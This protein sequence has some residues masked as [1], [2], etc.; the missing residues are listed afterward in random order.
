MP[1]LA[2]PSDTR[3]GIHRPFDTEVGAKPQD[4]ADTQFKVMAAK[5]RAYL[6]E[7]NIPER[8]A[9]EM[10][11]TPP[12]SVRFLTREEAEQY[13]LLGDD[14]AYA[15]MEVSAK[16]NKLGISKVE[17]YERQ[18]RYESECRP[19][20]IN[21]SQALLLSQSQE[22]CNRYYQCKQRIFPEK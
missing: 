9:D 10:I 8:L 12:E 11:R 18:T 15:D 4:R 19:L 13:G 1:A 17:Y 14:P 22:P 7:M 21:C 3:L 2:D 16:A 20:L 5:L 6:A